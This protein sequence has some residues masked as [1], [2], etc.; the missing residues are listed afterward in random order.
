[1][2]NNTSNAYNKHGTEIIGKL[3]DDNIETDLI[4]IG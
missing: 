3:A 1:M 2:E 4:E